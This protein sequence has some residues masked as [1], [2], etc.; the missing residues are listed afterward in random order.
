MPNCLQIRRAVSR[1]GLVVVTPIR[2]SPADKGGLVAG[3]LITEIIR[4][5]VGKGI[6]FDVPE[7]TTTKGLDTTDAV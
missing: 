1:D 6:K 3:D 4:D 2:G 5:G 7:V